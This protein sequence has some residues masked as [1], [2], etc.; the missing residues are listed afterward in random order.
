MA[1]ILIIENDPVTQRILGLMLLRDRHQVK[2]TINDSEAYA[3][4]A[5]DTVDIVIA[6]NNPDT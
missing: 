5:S 4:L 1:N 3:E 2:M 6:G